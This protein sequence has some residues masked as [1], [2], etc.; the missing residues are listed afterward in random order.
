MVDLQLGRAYLDFSVFYHFYEIDVICGG[1]FMYY[2]GKTVE[3]STF[4][5]VDVGHI[6]EMIFEIIVFFVDFLKIERL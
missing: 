1:G 4:L 2:M 6:F 3:I 5:F